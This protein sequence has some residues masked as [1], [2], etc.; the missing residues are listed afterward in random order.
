MLGNW[1]LGDY[2]KHESLSW[3]LE[4]LLEIGLPFERLG[5]TVHTEDAVRA[6]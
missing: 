1:S 3:T 4:W 6:R 5:V 2:Y